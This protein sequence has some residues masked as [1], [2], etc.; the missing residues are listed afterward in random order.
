MCILEFTRVDKWEE[1]T[2]TIKATTRKNAMNKI[3]LE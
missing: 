2:L 3:K 1:V